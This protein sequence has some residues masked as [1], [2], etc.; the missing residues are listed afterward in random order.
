[1]LSCR[2]LP[3]SDHESWY[4]EDKVDD[5]VL[6]LLYLNM[7]EEE[8]PLPAHRAWKSFPWEAMDRL[9]EKGYI[10]NPRGR[11]KSVIVTEEGVK[12]SRELFRRFFGLGKE[13]SGE[14]EKS[15]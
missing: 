3:T 11:A 4:D 9:H 8:A 5:V 6:A 2:R 10:G 13:S 15:A 12:R 14:P 7:W 1:M